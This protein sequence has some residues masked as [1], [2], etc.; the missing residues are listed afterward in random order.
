MEHFQHIWS[1][2]LTAVAGAEEE[3]QKLLQKWRGLSQEELKKLELR[4]A[5]QR[6]EL[7]RRVEEVVKAS[8]DRLRVPRR[9][10][11]AQLNARLDA[12]AARLEALS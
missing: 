10:E 11:I 1:Q 12:L 8:V 6:K 9:E 2:A 5:T 4:L 7:E 3:A